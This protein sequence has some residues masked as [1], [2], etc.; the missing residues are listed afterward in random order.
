MSSIVMNRTKLDWTACNGVR[1]V[2]H[3]FLPHTRL[4]IGRFFMRTRSILG[5][6]YLL[7]FFS[8][9][10]CVDNMDNDQAVAKIPLAMGLP[11]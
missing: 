4:T 7:T 9:N 8:R 2:S 5:Y 3:E 6:F 1:C 10:V 11:C